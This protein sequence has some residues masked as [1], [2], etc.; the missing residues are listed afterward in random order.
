[1]EE[2]PTL[3]FIRFGHESHP[4]FQD[5]L[6]RNTSINDNRR[7]H[8]GSQQK[9]VKV[10]KRSTQPDARKTKAKKPVG[11]SRL[12]FTEDD[13]FDIVQGVKVY[14]GMSKTDPERFE[15]S[16]NFYKSMIVEPI[17]TLPRSSTIS[18][19]GQ[20][21]NIEFNE[22][23]VIDNLP[24]PEDARILMISCEGGQITQAN[25]TP[26]EK[27]KKNNASKG[28]R[29]QFP[30]SMQF[31]IMGETPNSQ[32]KIKLFRNG[33][34]QIPGAKERDLSDIIPPL[35]VLRDYM[36]KYMEN[37][38]IELMWLST[39]MRNYICRLRDDT[40]RIFISRIHELMR[41]W[42]HF[43]IVS[44]DELETLRQEDKL[45]DSSKTNIKINE[46]VFNQERRSGINF[47]FNRPIRH[48][49]GK[50]LTIKVLQSGKI[51]FDGANSE[52]EVMELFYWMVYLV[53]TYW[54]DLIYDP[55][56]WVA[57][58]S[59]DSDDYPAIYDDMV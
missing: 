42:R 30:S 54:S 55:K 10:A 22:K 33:S 51:D 29:R 50:Q 17:M 23:I 41:K 4:N 11:P 15:K 19:T 25:F 39:D 35:K 37:S 46:I 2:E 53:Q 59:S 31:T 20:L 36:R 48:N 47:K 8:K 45:Q 18:V 56:V 49:E 26:K 5:M 58:I 12:Q 13:L 57:M 44:V 24:L 14:N 40:L 27:N 52:L 21:S 32:F 9:L 16:I 1:M 28:K 38:N 6:N 3:D 34:V 43:D 7:R